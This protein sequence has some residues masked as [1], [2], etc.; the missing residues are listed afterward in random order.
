[1]IIELTWQDRYS[2]RK[3]YR[4]MC[5]RLWSF[6]FNFVGMGWDGLDRGQSVGWSRWIEEKR[7]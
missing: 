3:R 4:M 1:M 7:K 6:L 5:Q 2:Q